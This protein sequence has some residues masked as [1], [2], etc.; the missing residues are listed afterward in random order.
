MRFG[1][2]YDLS[3]NGDGGWCLSKQSVVEFEEVLVSD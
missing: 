1:R 2:T 3:T